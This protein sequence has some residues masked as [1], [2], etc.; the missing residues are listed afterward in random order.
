MRTS[1]P[2]P[3][4]SRT[5]SPL[6]TTTQAARQRGQ[7]WR[8]LDPC[9]T[10]HGD[11]ERDSASATT[12]A[13]QLPPLNRRAFLRL[14]G[15]GLALAGLAAC[16]RPPQETIVP[17]VNAPEYVVPGESLF[18]ATALPLDGY[19]RGVLVETATGRPIKIEG[20]PDHPASLGAT[21]VYAQAAVLELWDPDRST[22]VLQ[23]GQPASWPEALAALQQS[24]GRAASAAGRGVAILTGNVTSPS[25]AAQLQG[26]LERWP[27][28]RWYHE[29]DPGEAHALAAAEAAFGE[30][31]LPRPHL[32]RA[33]VILTLDADPL[34]PGPEQVRHA[35]DFA[36]ARDAE[37]QAGS[38]ARL[39][40]VEASPTLTGAAADHRLPLCASRI[41]AVA[42]AL[43]QRLGVDLPAT[44]DNPLPAAWMNTLVEDLQRHPG[45]ALVLA[46][47][48]Q[49]A[50]VHR[51]VC[52]I[53]AR[54]GALGNTLDYAEPAAATATPHAGGL[55]ALAADLRA[56]A[57]ET[58]L[59][60]EVNPVYSAPAD[61]AFSEA[62]GHAATLF[63]LGLYRDETAQ[64]CH[65]HIPAAHPL[66]SWSDLR[67][68]DGTAS[69]VQPTIAPLHG[70]RSAGEL[71]QGLGDTMPDDP[72]QQLRAYWRGALPGEDFEAG[73]R[74]ALRLGLIAGTAL[75][76][77]TPTLRE[78]WDRGLETGAAAPAAGLEIQFTLDA[79]VYD[80]RFANNGWLQELPRPISKLTWGNAALISPASAARLGLQD[81]DVVRLTL[82]RHSLEAPVWRLPGQVEDC[83]TLPL[84]YGRR[85]AGNTGNG[86]GFDANRL[87]SSA[88]PWLATGAE[89]QATGRRVALACTQAHQAMAG[90]DL[91]RRTTL[92]ARRAA[93][94]NPLQAPP[95]PS[96]YPARPGGAH[97]W[98]MSIDLNACIGCG[99]CT[100]ACQAENNI[101]VVG[102]QE[103]M[104]GREMHWLRVD[105]Y[106][107]G[108]PAAPDI[109][110]QPVPCM[111]CEQAPCEVVCPVGATLHDNA[112]LNVQVYNRCVGTR[113]CSNN[114]P[115]KVRRFNFL[116]Y[117]DQDEPALAAGR[118]PQVSVRQRGVMEKCSYCLQRI[119][120]GRRQA[121]MA[122]RAL[123]DGDVVTAC[124]G[125]CP[126]RAIVFGDLNDSDSQVVQAKASRRDYVL[127][128][129]LNTRPR[130]SYRERVANPHPR[131][132]GKD[133]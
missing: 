132:Q 64:Q 70:G 60:L 113:F 90:E 47:P 106:F 118:N 120:A 78:D 111:H 11:R 114:C 32:D 38:Y 19:A 84:G 76:A 22:T 124:Q 62:L 91:V 1:R 45:R 125:V 109:L 8:S 20:N 63:H 87:R 71:L 126:T 115:Y 72:Y 68:A 31:L 77:R 128:R 14:T 88:A 67:A 105:R 116:Q 66:E 2:K 54:L 122:D 42:R 121:Q 30:R 9:T 55:A 81:G 23:N 103:V 29:P 59:L 10:A 16:A 4:A 49:P 93:A 73:W 46:G 52:A 25:L 129:E 102:K 96:L 69:L 13:F 83:V 26:L 117:A 86:V 82:G 21:D 50:N 56:G 119:N 27:R 48:R 5:R 37:S 75:P 104:R 131:L 43:A 110:F 12:A 15:G 95:Q 41:E 101:P 53:N 35:R 34:G 80:G 33:E 7:P 44:R 18:Y 112:G 28:A 130:T 74:R 57:I 94:G 58:L 85:H 24:R 17:Y 123:R 99:A 40:A 107:D 65:W 79:A 100:I 89:L 92:P 61:L 98:G 36:A 97:A 39:Y 127:L 108:S 3:A 51:I 133:T 6:T